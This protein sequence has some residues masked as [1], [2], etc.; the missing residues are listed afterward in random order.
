[1]FKAN[2]KDFDF[3]QV[4]VGWVKASTCSKSLLET[5]V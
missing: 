5:F 3:E 2:N 1:M 4:N